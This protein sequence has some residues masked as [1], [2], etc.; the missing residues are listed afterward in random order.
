MAKIGLIQVDNLMEYNIEARQ[1]TLLS[2]GEACLKEG[3]D[4]VFFPEA[5]Q[6]VK[7]RDVIKDQTSFEKIASAW[8]Q[9]C[10]ELA[11]KYKAYVVPWDYYFE[12]GKVYN[13]SYI[14]DRNGNEVGRYKKCNITHSEIQNG[15]SMGNDYPVFDLDFGKVGILICFDNYFPEA[16]ACLG[17][18]GAQLVLYPL[19][20]DTLK[21]Q[22][23]LKMR[24]RAVDHHFYMASTQL[25][26]N[27][28][29]Y[30]GIVN[31][32]GDVVARLEKANSFMVVD[33]EVGK[34]VRTNTPAIPG[35]SENLHEYLHKCRNYKSYK[36]LLNEGTM[37]KD[38]DEIFCYEQ[39]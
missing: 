19:Y 33:I 16:A 1:N 38:W 25:S 8:K 21:P 23:E 4:L 13:T 29:A 20:G 6:Y 36:S 39:K 27:N 24:A 26:L 11:K 5:F 28:I 10:A 14:L 35:Q 22:W 15:L 7:N 18:R 34:E 17:N 3:A 12:N 2:L 31:P 30:T 32:L 9:K 37:P